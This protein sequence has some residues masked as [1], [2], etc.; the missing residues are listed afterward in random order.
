MCRNTGMLCRR[1]G[2]ENRWQRRRHARHWTAW[3]IQPQPDGLAQKR[4]GLCEPHAVE[5]ADG[6]SASP[7]LIIYFATGDRRRVPCPLVR[8]RRLGD[9][10]LCSSDAD[11]QPFNQT[12]FELLAPLAPIFAAACGGNNARGYPVK[13]LG[14]RRLSTTTG[15]AA[16]GP[17]WFFV[18]NQPRRT[19]RRCQLVPI[20]PRR[21]L[22]PRTCTIQ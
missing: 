4:V 11:R 2:N 12:G 6:C 20:L 13:L 8:L 5:L 9:F 1:I 22:Q 18:H 3:V 15:V 21:P 19:F 10:A 16:E 14:W 7:S 17:L